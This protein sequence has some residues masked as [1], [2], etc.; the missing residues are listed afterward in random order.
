MIGVIALVDLL[1][2]LGNCNK[3]CQEKF[4]K[5]GTFEIPMLYVCQE[6]NIFIP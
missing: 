3:V 4:W 1:E 5:F 2:L 6:E